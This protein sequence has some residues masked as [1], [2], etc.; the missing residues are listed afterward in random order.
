MGRMNPKRLVAL[1]LGAITAGAVWAR[2]NR[3]NA[4]NVPSESESR[5]VSSGSEKKE[6]EGLTH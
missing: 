2:K 6:H 1:C 3:S 5:H 4:K